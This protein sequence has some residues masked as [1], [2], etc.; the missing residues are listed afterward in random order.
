MLWILEL[1]I[2]CS[3]PLVTAS[4]LGKFVSVF[5]ATVH[6]AIEMN[7]YLPVNNDRHLKIKQTYVR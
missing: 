7:E 5:N 3:N 4:N 1:E 2:L 6:S